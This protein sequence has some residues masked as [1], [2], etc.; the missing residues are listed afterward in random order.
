MRVLAELLKL[1]KT[2]LSNTNSEVL[3]LVE[4][5]PIEVGAPL[6][7]SVGEADGVDALVG[8][9][10]GILYLVNKKKYLRR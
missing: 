8:L 1:A 3:I 10:G 4:G 9:G 5:R 6:F 2:S 7:T